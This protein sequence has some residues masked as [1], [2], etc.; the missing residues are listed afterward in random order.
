[1]DKLR[2]LYLEG[3]A[4]IVKNV[5]YPQMNMSHFHGRDIMFLGVDG[6]DDDSG[7]ES[8][9]MGRWLDTEY[10]DYP[11]AY[12]NEEMQDPIAIEMGNAMSIAFHRDDGIPVGLNIQ[13]PQAFY[14]LINGVGVGGEQFFR[15]G[16]HAGDEYEYLWQFEGMSNAYAGRLRDVYLAGGEPSVQYPTEYPYL[17][18]DN[19]R[20]NPLS[21]QLSLIARLLAGGIKTRI[22]LCRLGGFDTHA[23]QV[24]SSQKTY[25]AH[26]ALLYHLFTSAKL[27]QDDLATRSLEEKVLTMT[28]SEFGRRV[29]DNESLGTDHG[30]SMPV[31]IFG[32]ENKIKGGL[33]GNNP[34][35]NNLNNGNME[36]STDYRNI[37][38][39]VIYDWFGASPEG[40]EASGFSDW[41]DQRLDI[42][43][44]TGLD[45]WKKTKDGVSCFPNPATV[46]VSFQFLM[47]APGSVTIKIMNTL[48][49]TVIEQKTG[50]QV[51]GLQI[52][53]MDISNLDP[54][55]YVYQIMG[56]VN[57]GTGQFVKL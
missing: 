46:E 52:I 41:A 22:F 9:W 8:G 17:C 38:A 34:D 19:F 42:F 50:N 55:G 4:V 32:N 20:N 15:P 10:P 33:L 23:G 1:M 11:D 5:G 47:P 3:K 49:Q 53:P 18:P 7:V 31:F 56:Q 39:S 45:N 12:P 28:F 40:I 2:E 21:G 37:Y 54:G 13:N 6:T 35:L 16:G 36:Y 14:D 51:Y 48:G 26:A 44:V 27:F 57:I 30:T 24:E 29:S 43:G 25:G